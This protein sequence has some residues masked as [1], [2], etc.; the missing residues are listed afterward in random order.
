MDPSLRCE[1]KSDPITIADPVDKAEKTAVEA[2]AALRSSKRMVVVAGAGM[3]TA[4]GCP[5]IRSS[6]DTFTLGNVGSFLEQSGMEQHRVS[7][8]AI[9][10]QLVQQAREA[11]AARCHGWL[12]H[13]ARH[14]RLWLLF[15]QNIDGLEARLPAIHSKTVAVHGSLSQMTCDQQIEY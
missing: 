15:Q 5:D 8:D 2:A 7:W 14:K 13:L 1:Q 12:D 10:K 4:A 11:Q 6:H 9:A 3:S